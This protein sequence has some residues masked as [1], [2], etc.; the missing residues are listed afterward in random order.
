MMRPRLLLP[1]FLLLALGACTPGARE[2]APELRLSAQGAPRVFLGGE[3][4][5]ALE[6]SLKG[7]REGTLHVFPLEPPQGLT[8]EIPPATLRPGE[9]L[10]LEGRAR[11]SQKLAP[12]EHR[13]RLRAKLLDLTAEADLPL[14][15]LAPFSLGAP[16]EL[17]LAPGEEARLPVRLVPGEGFSGRVRLEVSGAARASLEVDLS[18]PRDLALPLALPQGL[19]PGLHQATLAAS[20]EGFRLERP[21]LLRVEAPPPDFQ[22]SL[23]P[24]SLQVER[25]GSAQ[26]VLT[27][28]PQGGFTGTVGLSLVDPPQGL[29]LSPQSVQ[30]AGPDP[31]TQTLALTASPSTPTG[32]HRLTLRASGGGVAREA[33][34][35]LEVRDTPPP[36]GFA[37]SL[38]P[39]SLTV[40]RGSAAQTTLTLTPQGGFT[41]RVG[42]SLVGAPPGVTLSPAEVGVGGSTPVSQTLTLE[43]ASSVN[44]GTYALKVRAASGSLVREADLALA[45]TAPPPPPSFALSDPSPALLTLLQGARRSSG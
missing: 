37:L 35:A 14:R 24:Q 3:A 28:T 39:D 26:A 27:L 8:L 12:G 40:Q 15:A 7:G 4:T 31:V 20:W 43:V 29:S 2:E 11:A 42:L 10:R 17:A 5:L 6:V 33:A 25:G 30:V 23:A 1:L 44:P 36:P 32:S 22:V 21:L 41:G 13:V 38:S 34:L 9:T 16:S 19:G 18:G 45:V